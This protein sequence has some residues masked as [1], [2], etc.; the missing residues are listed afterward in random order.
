[1]ILTANGVT[2]KV[3]YLFEKNNKYWS[4]VD[5]TFHVPQSIPFRIIN[6]HHKEKFWNAK[7]KKYVKYDQQLILLL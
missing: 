1:M 2:V 4:D 5:R 7:K 6:T 3:P